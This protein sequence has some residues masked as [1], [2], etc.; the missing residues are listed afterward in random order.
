M[1]AG[2]TSLNSHFTQ[3]KP[4]TANVWLSAEIHLQVMQLKTSFV[5]H[6]LKGFQH[7]VKGCQMLPL[8]FT[9]SLGNSSGHQAEAL[10]LWLNVPWREPMHKLKAGYVPSEKGESPIPRT[11]STLSLHRLRKAEVQRASRPHNPS[12]R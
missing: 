3:P 12:A 6:S 10:Q 7:G 5:K 9:I 11:N 8:G 2:P 1:E 4:R